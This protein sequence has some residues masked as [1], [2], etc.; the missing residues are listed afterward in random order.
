[1]MW[2]SFRSEAFQLRVYKFDAN[3]IPEIFFFKSSFQ[4]KK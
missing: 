4:K 2:K 3:H 1:M